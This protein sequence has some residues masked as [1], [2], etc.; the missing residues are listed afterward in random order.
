M[1]LHTFMLITLLVLKA[2]NLVCKTSLDFSGIKAT[3]TA[4][5]SNTAH[6]TYL[7]KDPKVH[8]ALV[9]CPACLAHFFLT[10]LANMH[11][12]LIYAFSFSV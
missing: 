7:L 10:S 6:T 2:I 12:F 4:S 1:G 3:Q 9:L 8:T 5:L 11:H